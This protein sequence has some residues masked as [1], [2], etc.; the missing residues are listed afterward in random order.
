MVENSLVDRSFFHRYT[1]PSTNK[2]SI[3]TEKEAVFNIM[4]THTGNK[5]LKV[6]HPNHFVPYFSMKHLS[7]SVG[8][9]SNKRKCKREKEVKEDLKKGP[10]W[11]QQ[12][13]ADL[14]IKKVQLL[15]FFTKTS[16]KSVDQPNLE[17]K[18]DVNVPS[19]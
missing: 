9:A 8:S 13:N 5:A 7:K 11:K 6:W 18:G 12:R 2:E 4:W 15:T 1:T 16:K 3:S 10:R 17:N 14:Q 19:I